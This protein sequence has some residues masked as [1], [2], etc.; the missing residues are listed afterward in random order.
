MK[1]KKSVAHAR[2]TIERAKK[3]TEEEAE[4]ADLGKKSFGKSL[5]K[6]AAEIIHKPKS[7]AVIKAE[8]VVDRLNAAAKRAKKERE[9]EADAGVRRKALAQKHRDK[10][11]A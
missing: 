1:S 3:M 10:G 9:K 11:Y 5:L 4:I 2:K 7:K 8:A 6:D